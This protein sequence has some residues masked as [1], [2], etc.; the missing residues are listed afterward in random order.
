[1]QIPMFQ[2]SRNGQALKSYDLIIFDAPNQSFL[3]HTYPITDLNQPTSDPQTVHEGDSAFPAWKDSAAGPVQKITT[4]NSY[5]YLLAALGPS[6]DRVAVE[7]NADGRLE[8]FSI[9]PDHALVHRWQV[10]PN[11]TWSFQDSLGGFVRQIRVTHE[12]D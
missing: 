1:K 4:Q 2:T 6:A 11:S 8:E 3:D 12:A 9:G 5:S 10:A 7:R